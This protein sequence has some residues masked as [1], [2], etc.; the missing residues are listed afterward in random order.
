MSTV[1][2]AP[3]IEKSVTVACTPEEAFAAFTGRVGSWWPAHRYSV[4]SMTGR[5][6][7]ETIVFEPFV[8]GRLYETL[9]DEE[10]TWAIVREHDPPRRILLDWTLNPS[11]IE[12]TFAAHGHETRVDLVHRG[13]GDDERGQYDGWGYVLDC[14]KAAVES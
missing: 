4:F 3:A 13:L 8:G 11:E 2:I 14:F 1:A 7:P 10:C 5:A 6:L 12:V 9:G